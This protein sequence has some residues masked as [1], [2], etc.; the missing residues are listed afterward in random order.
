MRPDPSSVV[1]LP[2]LEKYIADYTTDV[3]VQLEQVGLVFTQVR[4]PMPHAMRDIMADLRKRRGK[5][6][7][8]HESTLSTYVAESVDHHKPVFQYKKAPDKLRMQFIDITS[9]LLKRLEG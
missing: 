6:V 5:T 2:L 1:G 8:D 9:E 7:F 4:K 3:G